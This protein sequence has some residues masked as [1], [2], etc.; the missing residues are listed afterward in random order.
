[1]QVKISL[2]TDSTILRQSC[3]EITS[4]KT[5]DPKTEVPY[6]GGL[7]CEKIFGPVRSYTCKCGKHSYRTEKLAKQHGV[8]EVCGVELIHNFARR[9]RMAH[10]RLGT[11]V[12]HPWYMDFVAK[13]LGGYSKAQLE[14]MIQNGYVVVYVD[15]EY[16]EDYKVGDIVGFEEYQDIA[17]DPSVVCKISTEG[18]WTVLNSLK[19]D[20]LRENGL[21]RVGG[22]QASYTKLIELLNSGRHPRDLMLQNLPVISPGHRP[23]VPV[24][25][26]RFASSDLNDL[27]ISVISRNQRLSKTKA[28]DMPDIVLRNEIRFLQHAVTCLFDNSERLKNHKKNPRKQPLVS[29]TAKLGGKKGILRGTGLGKRVDFSGR[30]VV[31]S[32]GAQLELDQVG[33]PRKIA[34]ELFKPF[35]I[36]YLIRTGAVMTHRAGKR[37]VERVSKFSAVSHEVDTVYN[38]LDE[39]VKGHP[40]MLNRAPTLHRL[41]FRAFYPV[42]H[43]GYAILLHPLSCS[44]FNADFDGDQLGV[45]LP[46]SR[47]SIKETMT[48][49][50]DKQILLPSSGR[51]TINMSQEMV[52]GIRYLTH[53]PVSDENVFVGAYTSVDEVTMAFESEALSVHDRIQIRLADPESPARDPRYTTYNTTVGRVILFGSVPASV[54]SVS[55]EDFNRVINKPDTGLL[56]ERVHSDEGDAGASTFAN[57]LMEVGFHWSMVSGCTI[58]ISD[59]ITSPLKAG[60]IE[61]GN[62][63]EAKY[64]SRL[65]TDKDYTEDQFRADCIRMWSHVQSEVVAD[66]FKRIE[67]AEDGLHSV[68]IMMDSGARGSKT[69]VRQLCGMRG[70]MARQDGTIMYHPITAN[71]REGM[72]PHEYFAS[73]NGSRKGLVDTAS[74]TATAGYLTRRLVDVVQDIVIDAEDCGTVNG[75]TV[76]RTSDVPYADK[77]YGR[78]LAFGVEGYPAGTYMT[79]EIAQDIASKNQ[80]VSIRSPALC[81]LPYKCCQK[82]YGMDPSTQKLVKLGEPVGVIAGQ[83]IGEPGTQLTLRCNAAGNLITIR[84]DGIVQ[85]GTLEQVWGMVPGKVFHDVDE[86]G[87]P[88]ETK[89]VSGM[90]V[91]DQDTF[92]KVKSIQRHEPDDVM[93][94]ARTNSGHAFISQGNHPNWTRSAAPPCPNCG[95]EEPHRFSG[96]GSCEGEDITY[97]KCKSCD[98]SVRVRTSEYQASQERVT[99]TRDL[100]GSLIGV[101]APNAFEETAPEV[102]LPAYSL[103]TWI[104]E[105]AV[106]FGDLTISSKLTAYGTSSSTVQLPPGYRGLGRDFLVKFLAGYVDGSAGTVSGDL[107]TIDTTSWAMASQI[108]DIVRILGGYPRLYTTTW[109]EDSVNQGYAVR[110]RLPFVLPSV[111]E[112]VAS[113]D[114]VCDVAG[115]TYR[116]VTSLSDVRY[117]GMVY[118]IAT[119][120]QGFTSNGVRTHN[121]FHSGGAVAGGDVAKTD[122]KSDSTGTLSIVSGSFEGNLSLTNSIV[123]VGPISYR[124]RAGDTLVHPAGSNLF[125]G[126][127]ISRGMPKVVNRYARC[128]GV[129]SA[130]VPVWSDAPKQKRS[131]TYISEITGYE[132]LIQV[133]SDKSFRTEY[134]PKHSYSASIKV[135]VGDKVE[136]STLIASFDLEKLSVGDIT[137]GLPRVI[138]LLEGRAPNNAAITSPISGIVKKISPVSHSGIDVLISDGTGQ[139]VSVEVPHGR[140]ICVNEG[141]SISAYAPLTQ[142]TERSSREIYSEHGTQAALQFLVSGV[143]SI[144]RSQGVY[145]DSKHVEMIVGRNLNWVEVVSIPLT[146]VDVTVGARLPREKYNAILASLSQEDRS[147]F[148]AKPIMYGI[149]TSAEQ[150]PS[151]LSAASFQRTREVLK[152]AAIRG[153]VDPLRGLKESILAGQPI[154][155]GT[156]WIPKAKPKSET[157]LPEEDV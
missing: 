55:F 120:T 50:A 1:M 36:S 145:I 114:A 136:P 72:D 149:T 118:D 112:T 24:A 66:T 122:L 121:T 58:G 135:D 115:P 34:I 19:E 6:D 116:E 124:L 107:I 11:R 137:G 46:L 83:S 12:V 29:L 61:E 128:T 73:I 103:G 105:G 108:A 15:D 89:F 98:A 43:D 45:H 51:T 70:L 65:S 32:S 94:L 100:V 156:G 99:F 109:R 4:I 117:T 60:F 13:I 23:I 5:I 111:K 79:K 152:N 35:L 40:V 90:E 31:T 150:T 20:D 49:M 86:D 78:V 155:A 142:D 154:P 8:C 81:E 85:T 140:V 143:Q 69:Q 76:P 104:S 28:N 16:N 153:A 96:H 54:E 91:L 93:M 146:G 110:F 47:K 125:R 14:E 37:L 67:E 139:V 42:L 75:M 151:W 21:A 132:V 130:I 148:V 18:I 138:A 127:V 113:T 101:T 30:S 48:F 126:D 22:H 2:S 141:D 131:R 68:W 57:S 56:I 129:V 64:K 119:E 41:S 147:A 63:K 97:L 95:S 9:E 123:S 3:G 144:Y 92:V 59:L 62:R 157:P 53:E 25:N 106:S 77:L 80:N 134:L 88:T 33:L 44:G 84:R 82:C 87:A 17:D 7:F 102:H 74:M 38:A 52:L 27:Y 71:L 10:I 26:G 133:D 39:V